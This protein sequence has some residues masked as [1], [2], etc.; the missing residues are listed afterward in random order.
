MVLPSDLDMAR[1]SPSRVQPLV[2]APFVGRAALEADADEEGGVEPAA[3]LVA[4]FEVHVG[5]PGE[6]VFL[7][8]DGEVAGAGIEPDIED[9]AL[10]LKFGAAAVGAGVAGAEEFLGG[11]FVP[12]VGGVFAEQVDD[13]IEFG[14][15]GD[16]LFA[17]LAGEGDDGDAPGALAGDA[18]IGAGG[19]HVADA[20]FAPGGPPL[21]LFNGFEGALAE[22]V[23][24][25]ADEPLFGG[26]EDGGFVAAPAVGVAVL[27]GGLGEEGAGGLEQ[28]NHE[29]VGFPDGLADE[30]FRERAGFVGGVVKAAGAIDGAIDLDAVLH[31]DDVVLLAVAGGGVDGAGA[32]FEGDVI[33][34]D[35]EGLYGR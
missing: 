23:A 4:A 28:F 24:L 32:L 9:V 29:W 34:E 19:D 17:G 21:D 1:P 3:I 30:G 5:R 31:A 13:V 11:A 22:I 20:L 18:P 14:T 33:G 16:V 2:S 27:D 15:V 10:L 6:V 12:D 26:A 8:Q 25:H 35:A 7:G